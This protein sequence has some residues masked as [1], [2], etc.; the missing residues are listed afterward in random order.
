MLKWLNSML[1]MGLLLAAWPSWAAVQSQAIDY[2][3][4][5]ASYT[6]Y[7]YW[8]DAVQGKRP[9]ILVVHEWWG[10]N[11]YAK[12]RAFMLAELGYVAFAVDIYGRGK[13]TQQREQAKTWMTEVTADLE[14]WRER[15][16][17]GL[18]LLSDNERVE[19]NQLAVIGYCFGGATALHLAYANAPVKGVVSFH[20][21]LPAA[22][23]SAKGQVKPSILVLHGEADNFVHP[24]V[25]ANFKKKLDEA[26]ADWE[27][28]VYGGAYHGFTNPDAAQFGMDNLRYQPKADQR[29]W[30][31]MQTFF[32]ELFGEQTVIAMSKIPG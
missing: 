22:P 20:G 1:L 6:G 17:Y 31:R 24:D 28:D 16:L 15:A 7:L 18:K 4:E 25:I 8:N 12:K 19:A 13:V 10:L 32:K 26:G 21:A 27:M 29:S 30:A 3:R 2:E 14:D 23:D 11:D 5:G 9:G